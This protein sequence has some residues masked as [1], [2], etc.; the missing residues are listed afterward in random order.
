ML[1]GDD[2]QRCNELYHYGVPGMKW[3]NHKYVNG[4]Y[5]VNQGYTKSGDS[6]YVPRGVYN[7]RPVNNAVNTGYIKPANAQQQHI[8]ASKEREAVRERLSSLRL[9]AAANRN[10][11]LE[12]N[13]YNARQARFN[14]QQE[15]RIRNRRGTLGNVMYDLGEDIKNTVSNA[16]N[17][18]RRRARAA[19]AT[20]RRKFNSMGIGR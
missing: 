20:I 4:D 17:N 15:S 10:R 7:G 19:K 6:I 12:K 2:M 13:L 9:S 11:R 14:A 8:H 5:G 18:L 1:G 3:R 16:R